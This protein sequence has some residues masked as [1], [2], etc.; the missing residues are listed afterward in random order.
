[1]AGALDH[2][3]Q[4]GPAGEGG[5]VVTAA[6]LDDEGLVL[7]E[8]LEV[9]ADARAREVEA[10][11]GEAAAGEL[12]GEQR[13]E[14][15]VHEALETVQD[16]H[17]RHVAR[18]ARQDEAPAHDSLGLVGVDQAECSPFESGVG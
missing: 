13:E 6:V 5:V 10:D 12:V 17:S 11:G 3:V 9:L 1:M 16:H 15:P 7:G 4:Q 2:V 8:V 14:A 18:P